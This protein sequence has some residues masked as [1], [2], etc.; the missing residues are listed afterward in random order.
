MKTRIK[1]SWKT[2]NISALLKNTP[3]TQALIKLLPIES[4][5]NTWGEEVYF[6]V[7]MS[8]SLEKDARQVVAPGTIC[9]WV[10]GNSL[11]LPFGPTP[12]SEGNES[13]LATAC[14]IL[15]EIEEEAN[16]LQ[17]IQPGEKITVE[18]YID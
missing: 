16:T 14:N 13:R 10:E 15:G 4:Y 9:F 18:K 8:V 11:A 17:F 3:S 2:G 6:S 12:I 1:I 7:P 5:A